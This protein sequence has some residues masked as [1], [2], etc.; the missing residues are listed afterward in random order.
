MLQCHDGHQIIADERFNVDGAL[1]HQR[2]A[3][4]GPGRHLFEGHCDLAHAGL[5]LGGCD[6]FALPVDL[7]GAGLLGDAYRAGQAGQDGY[8]QAG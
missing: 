7:A 4:A 6:A 8:A 2:A 3:E 1:Q 5:G